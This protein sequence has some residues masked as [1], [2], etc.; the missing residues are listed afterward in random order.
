MSLAWASRLV[1]TAS[2]CL[3]LIVAPGVRGCDTIS[4]AT[5]TGSTYV[6]AERAII[7]WD[8]THHLEH[9]I[10]QATIN[11]SSDMAF[12]VPTPETPQMGSV[13]PAIYDLANLVGKPAPVAAERVVTPWDIFAPYGARVLEQPGLSFPSGTVITGSTTLPQTQHKSGPAVL[14]Q[15]V[16]GF[17][18]TTLATDDYPAVAAWLAGNGFPATTQLEAWIK[19]YGA[20]H[21]KINAFRL[22]KTQKTGDGTLTTPALR[23][24][25][26]TDAPYY[27]YSEPADRQSPT[28]FS[29]GGR[30]LTVAV[31]SDARM[32]G[33]LANHN[34][35]PGALRYAGPA[36]PAGL[37]T[38]QPGHW[39]AAAGLADGSTMLPPQLTMFADASNPRNGTADLYFSPATD[40]GFYRGTEIDDNLS[41]I[42]RLDWSRPFSVLSGF[43]LMV[44]VPGAP[45]YCGCRMLAIARRRRTESAPRQES[46]VWYVADHLLGLAAFTVGMLAIF[47][48]GLVFISGVFELFSEPDDG[49][50]LLMFSTPI[51]LLC[52]ATVHCGHK[53]VH[54]WKTRPRRVRSSLFTRAPKR[55]TVAPAPQ[56]APAHLE[57]VPVPMIRYDAATGEI[58]ELDPNGAPLKRYDRA[59][60]VGAVTG[61]MT[62]IVAIT[63]VLLSSGTL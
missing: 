35:W 50:P 46:R 51:L 16:A 4:V 47:P 41:P 11:G 28:A 48:A 8:K 37:Q 61:G 40:Q 45:L 52:V 23:L 1:G 39:L 17:H 14:E 34:S 55:A 58:T 2:V 43:A 22:I 18:V 49:I 59:M 32:G 42:V 31:L 13:D 20:R 10:R 36:S 5:Y 33:A 19:G 62:A 3:A 54:H 30:L 63:V 9:F 12:L 57:A 25:F 26:H 53:A 24:T 21:W 15:D 7:I 27:P 29:P 44:L 6:E 38:A 60:G 56:P